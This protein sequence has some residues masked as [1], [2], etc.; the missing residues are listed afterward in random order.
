MD[1][2]L[3]DAGI[4]DIYGHPY[5]KSKLCDVSTVCTYILTTF[6]FLMGLFRDDRM[7]YIYGH[8]YPVLTM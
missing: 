1:I 6:L 7:V 2:F 5:P 3:Y 4:V 8:S